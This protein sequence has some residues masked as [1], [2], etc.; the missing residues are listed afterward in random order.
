LENM[1]AERTNW[2]LTPNKITLLL[3][4]LRRGSP[5]SGGAAPQILDLTESNPTRCGFSC[6]CPSG[7]PSDAILNALADSKNMS[8]DPSA[9]GSLEAREAVCAYYKE[10][11]ITVDPERIFLTASTSEAYSFLF[12]LLANPGDHILFPRP[13]YPLFEFLADINDLTSDFYP[14]QY[15]DGWQIDLEKFSSAVTP[16]TKAIV[17]VNPNNPTGSFIKQ[18]EL[19]D[20]NKIGRD[21][22]IPIICDEVF[23]DYGFDE[24]FSGL[25]LGQESGNLS[26]CLSGISKNLGLPQM[27]VSWI[28]ING[29]ESMVD[30]AV[31]RLE[32][33]ADTYLSVN[34]PSQ[35]ALKEWFRYQ[36]VIQK[37]IIARIKRNR[38]FLAECFSSILHSEGGWYVILK[39]PDHCQEEQFILDLLKKDRVLVQPGY[40]YDFHEEP[41]IVLSLLP[42]EDVFKEGVSRMMKRIKSG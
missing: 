22:G 16:A 5:A 35:N 31:S 29:P 23:L 9:K 18:E 13:S 37:E 19:R 30:E 11:N 17:L 8:Y 36:P 38:G 32:I 7:Y 15:S 10:K 39:L 20:I 12:R 33:I 27:K 4:E 34:T 42:A 25:S 3:E 26:F 40:F 1:F 14:L 2:K 24:N 6:L 21:H 41:Y 28:I